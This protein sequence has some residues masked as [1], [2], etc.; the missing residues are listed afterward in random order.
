MSIIDTMFHMCTFIFIVTLKIF[1]ALLCFCF[2][3]IFPVVITEIIK[4]IIKKP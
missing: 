2:I 4:D 3:G 1:I